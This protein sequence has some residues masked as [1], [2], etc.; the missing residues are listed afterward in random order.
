MKVCISVRFIGTFFFSDDP[1]R[2]SR[3]DLDLVDWAFSSTGIFEL[4]FSSVFSRLGFSERVRFPSD[5]V[6]V[7]PPLLSLVPACRGLSSLPLPSLVVLLD[8]CSRCRSG[9]VITCSPIS[10]IG[11]LEVSGVA[12]CWGGRVASLPLSD[13]GIRFSYSARSSSSA[14]DLTSD[15]RSSRSR[16]KVSEGS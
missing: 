2:P 10:D 12:Q 9:G 11:E 13:F 7:E 6:L 1:S 14:N 4:D 5:P 16:D 3:R 8:A 15:S